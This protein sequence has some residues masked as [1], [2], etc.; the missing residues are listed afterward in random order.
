MKYYEP[1]TYATFD[2]QLLSFRGRCA[3]KIYMP[4]KP[5]KYGLKIVS[6]NDAETH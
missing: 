5:D 4:K 6:I 1:S 3:F 2:E